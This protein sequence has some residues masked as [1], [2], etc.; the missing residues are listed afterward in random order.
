ME[1]S[2]GLFMHT[3]SN[4]SIASSFEKLH[5]RPQVETNKLLFIFKFYQC[6]VQNKSCGSKDRSLRSAGNLCLQRINGISWELIELNS[7]RTSPKRAASITQD[8][9]DG[10]DLLSVKTLIPG[11]Q[12]WN[13]RLLQFVNTSRTHPSKLI[14]ESR[15]TAF[16]VAIS[17]STFIHF[18]NMSNFPQAGWLSRSPKGSWFN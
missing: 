8:T 11:E 13:T 4:V 10:H 5:A 17:N 18:L 6:I 16:R 3:V 2:N 7:S 14:F 1:G 9:W 12:V 15:V